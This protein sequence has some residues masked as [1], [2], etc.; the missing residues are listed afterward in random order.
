MSHHKPLRGCFPTTLLAPAMPPRAR[1]MSSP[2]IL[3]LTEK[4][5]VVSFRSSILDPLS[6]LL[7]SSLDGFG[8]ADQTSSASVRIVPAQAWITF[9]KKIMNA[10]WIRL[11][12]IISLVCFSLMVFA[13]KGLSPFHHLDSPGSAHLAGWELIPGQI[14][15]PN[16]ADSHSH[17][18]NDIKIA[19]ADKKKVPK[20]LLSDKKLSTAES[21]F[22]YT[23]ASPTFVLVTSLDQ[24][25]HTQEYIAKILQNRKEYAKAYNYGVYARYVQDFE[26]HYQVARHHSKSWGK[27]ALC[28]AAMAAFPNAEYFWFLDSNAIIMNPQVDIYEHVVS[29][30]RLDKFIQHGTA[31][32][33]K[34][35]AGDEDLNPVVTSKTI[36]AQDAKLIFVQDEVGLSARS[37]VFKNDPLSLTFLEYWDSNQFK[38]Y[39]GFDR[40]ES[41]ALN[42]L[43]QWHPTILNKMVIIPPK[44]IAS[45]SASNMAE[46]LYTDGDFVCTFDCR[47]ELHCLE[48]F[49]AFWAG[50]SRVPEKFRLS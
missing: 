15:V 35:K 20:N 29:S 32:L 33:R 5:R 39:S 2:P 13:V 40:E 43:A 21:T 34:N 36:T 17:I 49:D 12:S 14:L 50:R 38:T 24:E 27:I 37:F 30:E 45:M 48:R 25:E 46:L 26:D 4:P 7:V 44:T 42:H 9:Q 10:K 1:K 23:D 18:R 8:T 3:P 28:R 22:K 41:S 19:P 6:S 31:V 16:L 11:I 47:V